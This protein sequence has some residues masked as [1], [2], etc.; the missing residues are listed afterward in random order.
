MGVATLHTFGGGRP[1][2]F[3][4]GSGAKFATAVIQSE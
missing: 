2:V 3:M 1:I 4:V